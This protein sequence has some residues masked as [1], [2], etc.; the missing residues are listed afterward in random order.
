MFVPK[1]WLFSISLLVGEFNHHRQTWYQKII[2]PWLFGHFES[3]TASKNEGGG[4]EGDKPYTQ[5]VKQEQDILVN[6]S[7]ARQFNNKFSKK[8]RLF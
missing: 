3:L 2:G 4:G 5:A 1:T 8:A 7:K 6:F